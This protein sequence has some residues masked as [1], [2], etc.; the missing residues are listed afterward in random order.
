MHYE[1]GH[2]AVHPPP[3]PSEEEEERIELTL[4][5]RAAEVFEETGLYILCA[6]LDP[7]LAAM[8]RVPS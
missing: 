4:A 7:P 1:N 6:G 2:V 5:A 8:T 3:G